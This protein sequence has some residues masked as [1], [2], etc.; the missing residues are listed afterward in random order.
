MPC[1]TPTSSTTKPGRHDI[2]EI[3]LKVALKH[4]QSNQI[5]S[6][7]RSTWGTAYKKHLIVGDLISRFDCNHEHNTCIYKMID[8]VYCLVN[9][10]LIPVPLSSLYMRRGI[11]EAFN[12]SLHFF[13]HKNVKTLKFLL[14]A[15]SAVCVRLMSW[16][17]MR[18]GIQ[19]GIQ[20]INFI[21]WGCE[22]SAPFL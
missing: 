6:C 2:A 20:L 9:S 4:Q 15:Y 5:Q 3:L 21:P 7:L 19:T 14:D 16:L 1:L 22:S 8:N 10:N 18:R 11:Q 13:A 12:R 17:Y